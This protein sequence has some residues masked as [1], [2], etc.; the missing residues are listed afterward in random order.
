MRYGLL[1][2]ESVAHGIDAFYCPGCNAT[3]EDYTLPSVGCPC[4]EF[5]EASGSLRAHQVARYL[6]AQEQNTYEVHEEVHPTNPPKHIGWVVTKGEQRYFVSAHKNREAAEFE[7]ERLNHPER[8]YCDTLGRLFHP[9]LYD[10]SWIP[11]PEGLDERP[12]MIVGYEFK[13]FITH[14][15]D[16]RTFYCPIHSYYHTNTWPDSYE[17]I[18]RGEV[19]E[20]AECVE[21]GIALKGL[22]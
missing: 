14:G 7:A 20:G 2:F 19:P 21:C 17:P 9:E 3:A 18:W 5:A 8:H 1:D 10:E 12:P 22:E 11:S 16:R 4:A 6:F 15:D 13:S